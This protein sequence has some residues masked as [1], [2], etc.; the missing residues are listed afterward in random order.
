MK[1]DLRPDQIDTLGTAI[2]CAQGR[3]SGPP[4]MT[5]RP[6]PPRPPWRQPQLSTLPAVLI[7]VAAC[8]LVPWAILGFIGAVL[9]R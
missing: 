4:H 6:S 1:L 9:I 2:A 7:L 8:V 5:A 3:Q